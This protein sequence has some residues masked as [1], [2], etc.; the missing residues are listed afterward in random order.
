MPCIN[1]IT[2]VVLTSLLVNQPTEAL[3]QKES[4]RA[5]DDGLIYFEKHIRPLFVQQC[6]S[7][8]GPQKQKGGLRLDSTDAIKKGG[9]SGV[10]VQGGDPAKSLIYRAVSYHDE[11]KMPP[12]GKLS[13]EQ[14]THIQRWIELGAALP[15]GTVPD[16]A[17]AVNDKFDLQRRLKLWS[18]QP[19]QNVKMPASQTRWPIT[20]IDPFIETKLKEHGLQPAQEAIRSVWLR[21]VTYDL[22]G[23]PPTMEEIEAFTSDKDAAA[24][25][26]VVDRLLSSSSYG[27][28]RAGTGLT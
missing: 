9:D 5:H 15:A 6:L 23:L 20:T 14:I 11:P 28:R 4:P 22:T 16:K 17:H 10:I 25:Q 7:C 2:I 3:L 1:L 24:Y 8:H 19:L 13:A 26:R 18:Y 12:R 21:R 27:E